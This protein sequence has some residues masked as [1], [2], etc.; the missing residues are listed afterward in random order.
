MLTVTFSSNGIFIIIIIII[1]KG[2]YTAQV[3]KGH[4]CAISMFLLGLILRL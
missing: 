1:I 3:R 4:K 2:I